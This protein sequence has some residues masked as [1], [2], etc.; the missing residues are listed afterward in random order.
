MWIDAIKPAIL[1]AGYEPKRI[2]EHEY[3]EGVVDEILTLI[4]QSRFVIADLTG[5]RGGVYY[6]AGFAKGLGLKVIFTCNEKYFNQRH[7]DTQ[8]Y[9]CLKWQDGQ[10][11]DFTK[12]LANRI[13]AMIGRG[14]YH[15]I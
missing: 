9:N 11:E 4:R 2:D 12:K 8:H 5:G 15:P 3:I 7:F 10:Y 6:E 14:N 1:L 13:E